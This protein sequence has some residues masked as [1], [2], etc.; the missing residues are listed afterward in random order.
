MFVNI[1]C[2]NNV[3]HYVFT[4]IWVTVITDQLLIIAGETITTKLEEP[5]TGK[6][7]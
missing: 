2:R 6:S 3:N 1:L 4:F 7:S 5:L